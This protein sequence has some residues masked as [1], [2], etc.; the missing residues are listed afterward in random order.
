ME[1]GGVEGV[2][3]IGAGEDRSCVWRGERERCVSLDLMG[4]GKLR[5]VFCSLL[6]LL[7]WERRAARGRRRR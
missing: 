2:E 1:E 3:V 5:F 4:C 7:G 6:Y